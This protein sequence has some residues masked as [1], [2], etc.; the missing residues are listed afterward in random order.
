MY[1][2]FLV[3]LV[4]TVGDCGEIHAAAPG[5]KRIMTDTRTH[6]AE[7]LNMP[8]DAYFAVGDAQILA[9]QRALAKIYR[10]AAFTGSNDTEPGIAIGAPRSVVARDELPLLVAMH[11]TGVRNWQ[12]DPKQNFVVVATNLDTAQVRVA[13]PLAPGKRE[14]TPRPSG[15]GTPPAGSLA[16]QVTNLVE[17]LDVAG[18]WA[19]GLPPG[20]YALRVIVYDWL[21]N[22]VLVDWRPA[23]QT[24]AV[25][26]APWAPGLLAAARD[27]AATREGVFF[28]LPERV[29]AGAP[30]PLRASV[31]LPAARVTRMRLEGEANTRLVPATLLLVALDDPMA[32]DLNIGVPMKSGPQPADRINVLFAT[33]VREAQSAELSAG[34]Y[35]AYLIVGANIA[36]P[37][38]IVVE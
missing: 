26:T 30:V 34:T 5:G 21:S 20:R 29:P 38:S 37:V 28:H 36:G 19:Q 32:F 27:E 4:I 18:L 16:E 10:D 14:Q 15:T 13:R 23:K 33:D 17:R 31:S 8:D 24:P 35:R 2:I 1:A 3:L 9:L 11:Q 22:T 7:L 25:D 12:V 6:A